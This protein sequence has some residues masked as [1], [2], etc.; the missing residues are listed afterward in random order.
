MRNGNEERDVPRRYPALAF[1]CLAWIGST[2]QAANPILLT[3]DTDEQVEYGVIYADKPESTPGRFHLGPGG[4]HLLKTDRPVI[5]TQPPGNPRQRF[6]LLPGG[7]Y[8]LAGD[9]ENGIRIFISEHTARRHQSGEPDAL[10]AWS[11]GPMREITVRAVA[12]RAYQLNYPNWHER[13][14]EVVQNASKHFEAAFGIRFKVE[15]WQ[16]WNYEDGLSPESIDEAF[17]QLRWIDPGEQDLVIAFTLFTL[18]GP[19][20]NSE[21]RGS[22]QY[23]S[24]Y[25]MIPDQW[26][27]TGLTTRL[28]HELCHVFGAFHVQTPGSVMQ[29]YFEQGTPRNFDF[30]YPVEQTILAARDVDLA[31]GVS[32]LDDQAARRIRALHRLHHHPAES[33]REDPVV[34]AYKNE[35]LRALQMRD[36]E[37][38]RQLRDRLVHVVGEPVSSEQS[39][40]Q[41]PAAG[42]SSE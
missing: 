30:G 38:A 42:S 17:Q 27:T 33:K 20:A 19:L 15:A 10:P 31:V 35:I 41:S 34:T 8:R 32:S 9:N 39:A 1:I 16:P 2:A 11:S 7:R 29:P 22:T 23:F 25:V 26:G 36:P 5:F 4:R 40:D 3:N 21:V 37:H 28:V 6:R 24:Q 18:P 14:R 12:G 13:A